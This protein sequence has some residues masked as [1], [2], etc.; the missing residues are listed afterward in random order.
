MDPLTDA[1]IVKEKFNRKKKKFME[2]QL[3][4]K[5]FLNMVLISKVLPQLSD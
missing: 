4:A 1:V 2:I 5:V 3:L